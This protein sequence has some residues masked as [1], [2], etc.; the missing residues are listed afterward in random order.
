MKKSTKISFRF[1]CTVLTITLIFVQKWNQRCF[2]DWKQKKTNGWWKD[3]RTDESK[4]A[5]FEQ[6]LDLNDELSKSI[7]DVINT[8][9][10]I[11]E[12]DGKVECSPTEASNVATS[13]SSVNDDGDYADYNEDEEVLE[14]F[15]GR[16]SSVTDSVADNREVTH[17][18]SSA[19]T[20]NDRICHL[21]W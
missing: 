6:N 18:K 11:Q 16:C 20:A 10:S 19:Q 8:P 13:S 12:V 3:D 4:H 15:S 21:C 17:T 1:A 2:P 14:S 7:Q 5:D 9:I